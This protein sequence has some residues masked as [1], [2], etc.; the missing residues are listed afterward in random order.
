V[1]FP[2]RLA[3]VVGAAGVRRASQVPSDAFGT[4]RALSLDP[5]RLTPASP[6]AAG[7]VLGSDDLTSSPPA[8]RRFE[9]GLLKRGATPA[10]G[11]CSS[12]CTPPRSCSAAAP[13][14]GAL[15]CPSP[16]QHSGWG[17]WLDLP[18]Q[19]FRPGS[20]FMFSCCRSRSVWRDFHPRR[21]PASP[22]ALRIFTFHTLQFD[23]YGPSCYGPSFYRT[24]WPNCYPKNVANPAR[25][26]VRVKPSRTFDEGYDATGCDFWA[27]FGWDEGSGRFVIVVRIRVVRLC[28][29]LSCVGSAGT[30]RIWSRGAS[31]TRGSSR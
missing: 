22:V 31:A 8:F 7:I 27:V 2:S 3:P 25:A 5:G 1:A 4:C 11:P 20:L 12:L 9:A 18:T 30:R 14:F 21:R 16:R 13:S 15:A 6:V 26:V 10:C 28:R 23:C 19:V 29:P 17:G 24:R